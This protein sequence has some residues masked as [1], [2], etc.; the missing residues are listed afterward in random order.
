YSALLH[1][2]VYPAAILFKNSSPSN[3][4]LAIRYSSL[5][6]SLYA[7]RLHPSMADRMQA[8]LGGPAVDGGVEGGIVVH[9]ELAV[10]LEASFA[11]ECLAP[12]VIEAGSQIAPLLFG[13][14]EPL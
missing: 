4:R 14:G 8:L 9:F 3:R 13:E 6:P 1:H 11:G 5:R 10:E 2:V 7:E 12:E